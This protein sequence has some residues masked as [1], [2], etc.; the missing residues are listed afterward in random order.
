MTKSASVCRHFI[1][2]YNTHTDPIYGLFM[3]RVGLQ[4]LAL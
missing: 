1:L 2:N 3:E 4:P